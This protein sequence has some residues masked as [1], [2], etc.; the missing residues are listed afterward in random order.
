MHAKC[1]VTKLALFPFK[2]WVSI[3]NM[4]RNMLKVDVALHTLYYIEQVG[5]G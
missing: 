4:T 2:Q 1:V 3:L 5:H